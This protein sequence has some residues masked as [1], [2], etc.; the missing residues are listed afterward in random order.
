VTGS[1]T[2]I[3]LVYPELLGTY[4]DGGNAA[5]LAQR[6]RWRDRPAEVVT[7]PAGAAVPQGCD[8]YLLGGGE[9]EP[10][11]LAAQNLRGGANLRSA[12]EAGA[13][14]FAVCAGFQVVGES[15][16]GADGGVHD[17]V[18]L[19]AVRTRRSLDPPD[20]PVPPRAVGDLV[21]D[22]DPALGLPVLLGY[23]NHGGRTAPL[24]AAAGRPL[25][26]VR[27]GVGN[28]TPDR[29]EGWLHGRV[30]ATYLHGPALAQNPALADLLLAMV[31]GPLPPLPEPE[32]AQRLRAARARAL[33]LPNAAP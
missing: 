21:V 7:V 29:A 8:L 28:G 1:A 3:A 31:V 6:L 22:P 25:G 14:V 4:G 17:G 19:L 26:T 12:V 16:P 27:A 33:G 11:L 23:E 18:G 15:F 9:D 24:P 10:Q 2:R 5:I 20:R 13:V 30:L 32:P